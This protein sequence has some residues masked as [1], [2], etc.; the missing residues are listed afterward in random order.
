MKPVFT[1][2]EVARREEGH[3]ARMLRELATEWRSFAGGVMARGAPGSWFNLAQGVGLAGPVEPGTIDEFVAFYEDRALDPR[4][5]VTPF[6]HES[7]IRGLAD[8]GFTIARFET[9]LF[10]PL[11]G[12]E[13][14]ASPYP[15]PGGVRIERVDPNDEA[16][17]DEYARV[18]LSGFLPPG[19]EPPVEFLDASKRMADGQHSL[20]VRAMLDGRCVG[21]GAMSFHDDLAVFGG[22]TVVPEMRRKGI[23]LAMMAWRL[24]HAAARGAVVATI[25][26]LPGAATE[27]N[28]F[29][30]GFAVAY[31]KIVL[32]RP[33]PGLAPIEA[34]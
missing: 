27:S 25:G 10:R 29:R 33:G 7:I 15:A 34:G 4:I 2:G 26:S 3:A 13:E 16:A 1:M 6:A 19:V 32:V 8:R 21:A 24:R 23:Q 30:M 9:V 5:E 14:I 20:G 28:A 31:S 11:T 22:V 18:S 17:L 12:E